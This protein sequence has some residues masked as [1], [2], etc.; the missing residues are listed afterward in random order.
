MPR[1]ELCETWS[2]IL[3]A[4]TRAVWELWRTPIRRTFVMQD[5][6]WNHCQYA[7]FSA[8]IKCASSRASRVT[9]VLWVDCGVCI[10]N[11]SIVRRKQTCSEAGRYANTA[12]P[13]KWKLI[14]GFLDTA[15]KRGRWRSW[16]TV[17]MATCISFHSGSKI[18]LQQRSSNGS[19][20]GTTQK[21]NTE[22]KL[23]CAKCRGKDNSSSR[24]NFSTR[25]DQSGRISTDNGQFPSR[26]AIKKSVWCKS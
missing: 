26:Y 8:I 3:I 5:L 1:P 17:E 21:N 25:K 24:Q 6:I 18:C 9:K 23:E 20:V 7:F 13:C 16:R 11:F 14:C 4:A 10:F 12:S 2:T 15:W 22:T 19:I